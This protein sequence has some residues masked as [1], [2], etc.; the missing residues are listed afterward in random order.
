M[1]PHDILP[2]EDDDGIQHATITQPLHNQ[3]LLQSDV[4]LSRRR[5]L[6]VAASLCILGARECPGYERLCLQAPYSS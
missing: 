3:K 2:G 4:M 1:A 5:R 6:L